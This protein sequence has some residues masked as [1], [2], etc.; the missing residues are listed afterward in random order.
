LGQHQTSNDFRAGL[1]VC[2]HVYEH[3]QIV[4]D[5]GWGSTKLLKTSEHDCKYVCMFT[6]FSKLWLVQV[7]AAPN[8][9]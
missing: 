1:Q 4:A 6:S 2:V 8:F 3:F 7:G 5:A 9:Y